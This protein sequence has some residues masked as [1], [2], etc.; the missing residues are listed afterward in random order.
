MVLCAIGSLRLSRVLSVLIQRTASLSNREHMGR[1]AV[2][3]A[4][5]ILL[6]ANP[7]VEMRL[8]GLRTFIMVPFFSVSMLLAMFLT[9]LFLLRALL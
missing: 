4:Q 5:G 7:V 3:S 9:S 2:Y 1:I 6:A 8:H